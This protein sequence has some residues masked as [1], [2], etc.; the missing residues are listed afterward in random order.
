[1]SWSC[2]GRDEIQR[3]LVLARERFPGLTFES[4]T[5][6]VGFG[7]VIDEARVQD[8]LFEEPAPAAAAAELEERPVV[9]D[10]SV[11]PMWDDPVT[12]KRDVMSVWR[13]RSEETQAATQLNMPVRVTVHHDDLQ[14][15][16]VELS[17]PAALLKRALGMRVDPFEMSLSEVQSA[18]I[19]PVGAGF[20]TYE[21]ARPELSLAPPP[22]PPTPEA[23]DFD[24]PPR[25]RR[26]RVLMLPLL[27][28]LLALVAG[29]TWY[30]AVKTKTSDQVATSP[31][32]TNTA[33][34]D[35]T[36]ASS[37]PPSASSSSEPTV[38]HEAPSNAP[39]RKPNV[40]LRSD[41]AFGFNSATL[42][43]KA[44]QAIA[45]VARQVRAAGLAGTIYVEGYTDNLGSATYGLELSRRRADAVSNYLRTQLVGVTGI[46]IASIG[47]GEDDPIA[48]NSTAAG[49]QA[50][51]RVTITLPKP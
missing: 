26:G 39:S 41:L 45:G 22:P 9:A 49:R 34:P 42:S 24:Q 20:T 6:H 5:R 3:I 44:R 23:L 33:K 12:E 1:M 28:L 11:H 4:R 14:V 7:L 38:T 18:F 50:N 13:D 30:V 40:T 37:A 10:P 36:H 19:A 21:L 31:R 27:V 25:H 15:H 29:G 16:D 47:H 51:R 43:G 2:H 32:V 35:R 17:F 48:D 46:S 8:E